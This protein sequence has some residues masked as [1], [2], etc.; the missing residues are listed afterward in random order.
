MRT[1][2]SD[3]G[4]YFGT[5]LF[6]AL[7]LLIL[8]FVS[9]GSN[10]QSVPTLPKVAVSEWVSESTQAVLSDAVGLPVFQLN[11]VSFV[12]KKH[13]Q[14]FNVS[15]KLSSDSRKIA[16][17]YLWLCQSELIIKPLL[18]SRNYYHLSP[19]ESEVLPVLS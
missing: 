17:R 2:I 7:F 15:F 13:I 1:R 18:L 14:F 10:N 12:D 11:W 16:Q 9:E 6:I 5:A 8:A 4:N 3:I 19:K